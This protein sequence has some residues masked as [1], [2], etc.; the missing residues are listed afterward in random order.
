[1]VAIRIGEVS[2]PSLDDAAFARVRA[3]ATDAGGRAAFPLLFGLAEEADE[4][5]DPAGLQDE[6]IRLAAAAEPEVA[7]LLGRLRD[8]LLTAVAASGE[9]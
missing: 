4:V 3:A 8:D 2:V 6:V 7:L 9:G 1:M 5:T